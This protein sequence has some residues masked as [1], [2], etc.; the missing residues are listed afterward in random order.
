MPEVASRPPKLT[1]TGALYQLPTSGRRAGPALATMGLVA[2]RLMVTGSLVLVPPPLVAEQ[3]K[4][5]P[6][7]SAVMFCVLQPVWLVTG[8][9]GSLTVQV[10]VTLSIYQSLVPFDPV[11]VGVITGG[12]LSDALYVTVKRSSE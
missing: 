12:V 8:D 9:S 11:T 7:V 1:C 6:F 3:V 2:S 5:T 4:V 10:R